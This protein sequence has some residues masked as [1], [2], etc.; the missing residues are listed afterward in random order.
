MDKGLNIKGLN[1]KHSF[2]IIAVLVMVFSFLTPSYADLTGDGSKTN[3]Y[4]IDEPQ[5]LP[6]LRDK[7]SGSQGKFMYVKQTEDIDLA[8]LSG[9]AG[10]PPMPLSSFNWNKNAL[11]VPA[12]MTYFLGEYDGGGHTISNWSLSKDKMINPVNSKTY[13]ISMFGKVGAVGKDKSTIKNLNIDG[14]EIEMQ[15]TQPKMNPTGVSFIASVAENAE[16]L[17]CHITNSKAFGAG[18]FSFGAI[19]SSCDNSMISD[20]SVINCNF[21]PTSESQNVGAFCG[22]MYGTLKNCFAYDVVLTGDAFV[23][24]LV[25]EMNGGTIENCGFNG[26]L[27]PSDV[28]DVSNSGGL[29]GKMNK[30]SFINC[31]TVFDNGG[32]IWKSSREIGGL[33]GISAENTDG[34][35]QV[36]NCYA[37]PQISVKQSDLGNVALFVGKGMKKEDFESCYCYEYAFGVG[38]ESNYGAELTP[39]DME[40]HK[41]K[42]A[43]SDFMRSGCFAE[44]LRDYHIVNLTGENQW[45]EDVEFQNDTLPVLRFMVDESYDV[46]PFCHPGIYTL[47]HSETGNVS[48]INGRLKYITDDQTVEGWIH[49][50]EVKVGDGDWERLPSVIT[51][52]DGSYRIKF[53]EDYTFD[54][55]KTTVYRAFTFNPLDP[56]RVAYGQIDTICV[57]S[58]SGPETISGCDSLNYDGRWFF[59]KDNGNYTNSSNEEVI[60]KI[61]E[62][63]RNY[64]PLI[65]GNCGANTV[66]IDG[67]SYDH[68]GTYVD[69]FPN[70]TGCKTYNYRDVKLYP[71]LPAIDSLKVFSLNEKSYTYTPVGGGAPQTVEVG[72]GYV[73]EPKELYVDHIKYADKT[74]CDSATIVVKYVIPV[75]ITKTEDSEWSCDTV[76]YNGV[77]YANE[78]TIEDIVETP[79]PSVPG[80]VLYEIRSHRI[81]AAVPDTVRATNVHCGSVIVYD[82]ATGIC[83]STE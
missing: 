27:I 64:L 49:G 59:P 23:G 62:T 78:T 24:G 1:I 35:F 20:C 72:S 47:S 13:Y 5:D 11:R 8:E 2:R 42:K 56:A 3:P 17:N 31:F 76:I 60:I 51:I 66:V 70:L 77:K 43:S 80:G 50:L 41:L 32:K 83:E 79:D 58:S 81:K 9:K 29:C 6:D 44:V 61:G 38:V 57:G 19:A 22:S 48:R 68:S 53:Y 65:S 69:S 18:H 30:G 28:I 10:R 34:D 73:L 75:K 15:G 55:K 7:I 37:F 21:S 36:K 52:P 45:R 67:V 4:I 33:I 40:E 82:C 46:E 71:T 54:N 39:F 63:V 12:A 16:I 26:T 74:T 25:G 14:F